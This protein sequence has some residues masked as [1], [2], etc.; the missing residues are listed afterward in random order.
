MSVSTLEVF[1]NFL[2]SSGKIISNLT[3][4]FQ[5]G[6]KP[7]KKASLFVAV[8]EG[9]VDFCLGS[10]DLRFLGTAFTEGGTTASTSR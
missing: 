7:P 2:F 3:R 1:F 4:I 6:L 10:D 8:P 9:L 5:I